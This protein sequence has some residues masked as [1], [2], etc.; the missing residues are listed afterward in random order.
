[1]RTHAQVVVIGGGVVGCSV[2]YHLT[3]LG[4]KDVVLCE[5]KELTAGSSW[6]AAGGFHA[7]NSDPNV[8]RLQA[9]TVQLYREIEAL[10]GQDVGLHFTGG[11]NVA[12]TAARWDFLR[13]DAARHRVLGLNSRLVSPQEIRELCPLMDV[14]EVLGGIYDPMEGHLDPYGATHAFAKAARLN[15]AE[16]YRHAMVREL[17]AH[18]DGTWTVSTDKGSILAEHV[19][20]AGGLW[21][22]EV[23]RM[24]GVDL[25]VV[26]MEHHYLLTE[27]LPEIKNAGREL[28]LILDLDGEIYLRQERNGVL[29]GVY[30]QEATPWAVTGTPWDYGDTELL[31]PAL[32]RLTQSLEKGFRRFPSLSTVGIRKVVNGPFTFSPDGN[33]LVGPVPGLKN[34]WVACGVMAGFAQ[35]GGVGLALAQWMIEGE[36]QSDIFAMDVARFGPYATEPYARARAREFYAKRFQIAYPNEVWPAGR[37]SRTSAIHADLKAANAVFGVSYG[38]EVALYFAAAAEEARELPS[39]RRSNAFARVG[40]ECSAARGSLGLLDISPFAKYRVTG[41]DAARALDRLLAGRLPAEGQVRITPMLSPTGRLMGDLTTLRL[42]TEEFMLFGSGYLQRWH[43]RW[44]DTHLAA[45]GVKVENIS[46]DYGG[47]GILGPQART[48]LER[49]AEAKVSNE[50]MPFMTA[51]R[52]TVGYAPATVARLSV[53]GELGYEIYVPV[54]YLPSLSALLAAMSADLNA[55]WMGG[56]AL[57]ALRLEKGF[58]IWSREYTPDYTPRMAGLSRFIAYGKGDFIGRVAALADR[59]TTP[60]HR[61]VSLAIDAADADA[62]GYEPI[63]AHGE[64]VGYVTSGGYGHCVNKS[65][66]MGY[67]AS[68]VPADAT[69]TVD[70]LGEPRAATLLQ[71]P[72]IDPSG[73]RMRS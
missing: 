42:A 43:M 61:L 46:D 50:A 72:L 68:H 45:S 30:E 3:K 34:F 33:P 60:S 73:S 58:G 65:L 29:L 54:A 20:N 55:R 15:G 12:A 67:L 26:P 17:R 63:L 19:V 28:P 25:P 37:P 11:L 57:N 35:G 70:I 59:D 69:L 21:A 53:S 52:M 23:G 24:A 2:L 51:R 22:R 39:L 18:S 36:P 40:E 62:T 6:H 7:L 32:E 47:I 71:Q 8:S 31:P 9:Y 27:D 66:A 64:L 44:F 14:S 13:A 1:M 48:L 4:W 49:V 16:I 5:R 56:Y 10:S 41:A 38:T